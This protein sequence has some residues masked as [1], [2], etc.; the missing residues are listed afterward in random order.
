MSFVGLA[1]GTG[2]ERNPSVL[3]AGRKVYLSISFHYANERSMIENW[4]RITLA[5][6]YS[7]VSSPQRVTA[8]TGRGLQYWPDAV[9]PQGSMVPRDPPS[10]DGWKPTRGSV[11]VDKNIWSAQDRY[12]WSLL[13]PTNDIVVMILNGMTVRSQSQK[14]YHVTAFSQHNQPQSGSEGDLCKETIDPEG[15]RSSSRSKSVAQTL[16]G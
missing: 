5:F 2:A 12:Q 11:K 4:L 8:T 1:L 7:L 16:D 9:I 3:F 6:R 14:L 15:F 10:S 13:V